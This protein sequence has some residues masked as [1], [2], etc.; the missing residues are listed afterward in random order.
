[1]FDTETKDLVTVHT[2]GNEQLSVMRYSPG[3]PDRSRRIPTELG[4]SVR[5]PLKE[6]SHAPQ[7]KAET[8]HAH[9]PLTFRVHSPSRV[10]MLVCLLT[11]SWEISDRTGQ[12]HREPTCPSPAAETP[13]C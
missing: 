4:N 8:A 11:L 10:T 2:D 6:V 9:P 13:D 1:M 3:E 5:M 12:E 7:S